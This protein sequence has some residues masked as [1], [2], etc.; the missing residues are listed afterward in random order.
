MITV[1]YYDSTALELNYQEL[2]IAS[3]ALFHF[4]LSRG[5]SPLSEKE[6]SSLQKKIRRHLSTTYEGERDG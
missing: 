3:L 5:L 6:A 2:E 4:L 1:E